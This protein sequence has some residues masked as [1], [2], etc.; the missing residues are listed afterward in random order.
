MKPIEFESQNIIIGE[1]QP[2]YQPLPAKVNQAEGSVLSCW[3]LTPEE[4]QRVVETGVVWVKQLTFNQ[5]LQ[6][7]LVSTEEI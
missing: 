6:P 2:E 4:I 1:G 7:V 5:D 3:K